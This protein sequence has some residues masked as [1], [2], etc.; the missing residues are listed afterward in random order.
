MMQTDALVKDLSDTGESSAQ[1]SGVESAREGFVI[2]VSSNV[3]FMVVQAVVSFWFTPYL[4][5]HL[6]IAVYGMIP[7]VN[8]VTAYLQIFT[9]GF[10]S[11]VN[12]FLTIDLERGDRLTA[13]KTF[14]TALFG[15][16]GVV[17]VLSPVALALSLAFPYIFDVPPGWE[18]D[19][20]W[21]FA[22]VAVVFFISV[23]GSNFAVSSYAY[24]KFLLRNGV[25]LAALFARISLVVALFSLFPA[26]LTHVGGGF[27]I[28]AIVF[29]LSHRLIWHKLTPELRVQ[30]TAFDRS[31]LRPLMG[32]GGWVVVN[33]VGGML[34]K[35]VDLIVVNAVFGA[36][37]TGGY[38]SVLQFSALTESLGTSAGGVLVPIIFRKYAQRDFTGLKRLASQS[39]KLLGLALALPVGLLCGFSRPL[40]SIWLG[41]SFEDLSVLLVFLVAHL[42]L[43]LSVLP[44][45]YVQSAY[46][47]IRWPGIVTL[48]SGG[49]NLGLAILLATWGGW[50]AV[51][52]ALAGAIVWTAKNAM[53]TPIYT[54][55]VMR[56]PWWTFLPQLSAS[57][58]GTFLVGAAAY[59]LTLARM[60]NSWLTLATSAAV[61]SL[62]YALSVGVIGLNRTDWQL[63]KD[64]F[65][66]RTK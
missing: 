39:V 38:G 20:S 27:L 12:R 62:L 56:L 37:M 18:S 32:M 28:S 58:I 47:R 21:L 1:T 10:N 11:A 40:L 54:A 35:R 66:W 53:Y 41:P 65:P 23:I 64:L 34:L 9:S 44:L 48:L 55:Q 57:V 29:Y 63:L 22:L 24:S 33:R 2:N 61:V 17:L 42:S 15:V 36:A 46:N 60:P 59:G 49:A 52:V 25:N 26:R 5:R 16:V 51:G 45:L 6:G 30:I 7:L 8:S 31:R 4:I 3:A 19:A 43:N 14:N 50:G 13:N